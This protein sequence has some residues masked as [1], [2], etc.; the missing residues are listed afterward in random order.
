MSGITRFSRG[1]TDVLKT[2]ILHRVGAYM[3]TQDID[4]GYQPDKFEK[5]IIKTY[6]KKNYASVADVPDIVQS[7]EI[8]YVK[9]RARVHANVVITLLS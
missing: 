5:W 3:S 1:A 6:S 7:S 4:R 9:S 2:R 8:D